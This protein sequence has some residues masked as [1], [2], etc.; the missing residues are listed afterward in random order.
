MWGEVRFLRE[1]RRKVGKC[2]CSSLNIKFSIC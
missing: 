1:E 2:Y